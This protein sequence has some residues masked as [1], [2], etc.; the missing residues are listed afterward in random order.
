MAAPYVGNQDFRGYLSYLGQQG[1]TNANAAL[2][3]T[4]NDAGINDNSLQSYYDTPTGAPNYG[5][6]QSARDYV[7]NA[8]NTYNSLNQGVLGASTT[9]GGRDLGTLRAGFDAQKQNIYGSSN[10]AA[11]ALQPG[12]NRNVLDTIHNLTLGQQ[13]IDRQNIN[14]ES[15]KIQGGRSILDMVGRGIRSGGVMLANKNAGNSSAAGALANAYGQLG[16]RQLSDIGNQ[17]SKNA[18]DIGVAQAEQD[19]QVGQA[20]GKF[21]ESLMQN[22]N[23]IVNAARD[24]FAQLDADMANASLPERIAIEQ[25]KEKVRSSVLGQLQQYDSQLATGVG[26]IH[27][28]TAEQNRD[29]A[30][31]QIQAGQADPNLFRYSTQ[32]PAQFQGNAPSGGNLPLFSLPR[33]KQQFA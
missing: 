16:Q 21:H 25:E 19:Y 33:N 15:S 29:T 27:A 7:T 9:A 12:L 3:Y 30:N 31:Q 14:N 4:G 10:D 1:D 24:R 5:G 28:T 8:Y 22:V 17:Y 23:G 20:P 18:G 26:G 11:T 2:N 6:P 13:G 32:A